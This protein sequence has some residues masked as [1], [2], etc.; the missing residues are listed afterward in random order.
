MRPEFLAISPNN[1]IPAI[2]DHE[3]ACGG[4]PLPLFESGAILE[5]LRLEAG[6]GIGLHRHTG[7]VHAFNLQ[8]FRRLCTGEVVGPGAYVYEPAGNVDWWKV[9][10]HTPLVVMVV[11]MGAVEYLNAD[12]QVTAI[13]TGERLRQAYVRHC[14]E[15]G[16]AVADLTG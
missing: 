3:P 4:G 12:G 16:I 2:V 10:G 14:D 1:R 15:N 13:Y 9:E 8:G 11:A 6:A 7:E 5:L